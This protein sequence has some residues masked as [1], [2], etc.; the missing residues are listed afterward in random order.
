MADNSAASPETEKAQKGEAQKKMQ[1]LWRVFAF[2][3]EKSFSRRYVITLWK[4]SFY[5]KYFKEKITQQ[6]LPKMRNRFS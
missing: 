4:S 2:F 1:N 6:K 3:V 5:R